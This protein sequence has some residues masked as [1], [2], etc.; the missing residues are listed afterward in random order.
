MQRINKP[1]F[2]IL[3]KMAQRSPITA[4]K[5]EYQSS[6]DFFDRSSTVK[7]VAKEFK[8]RILKFTDWKDGMPKNGD[9]GATL[10]REKMAGYT[11][12]VEG[13][14]KKDAEYFT[15]LVFGEEQIKALEAGAKQNVDVKLFSETLEKSLGKPIRKVIKPD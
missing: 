12:F 9:D 7:D 5:I 11:N 1:T 4:K 6:N 14:S 8:N 13:L 15:K 10:L 2:Q 3:Q